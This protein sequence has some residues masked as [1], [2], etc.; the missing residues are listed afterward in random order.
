[1]KKVL[2]IDADSMIWI[3][4][5]NKKNTIPKTLDEC[6]ESIDGLLK[7]IMGATFGT[8]YILCITVGRSFRYEIY[9]EYKGNRKYTDKSE[10]FDR[11]K[12]YLIIKYKAYYQNGLEADDVVNI[13][14][15]RI[16]NSFI[17]SADKDVLLLEG[18]NF[19]YRHFKWIKTTK[20]ESEEAFWS[21]MV[22]GQVGDNIKGIPGKGKAFVEKL[23]E[24]GDGIITNQMR[25]FREYLNHFGE[26]KG[27][28]E[29]YKNY[30]SLKIVDDW[31]LKDLP[32][33][34]EYKYENNEN[35]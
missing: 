11:I 20:E 24:G 15:K 1:M 33:P 22:S 14:H 9:P 5:H 21:D 7:N 18:K 10:H 32:I 30:K 26:N 23:F 27:I 31:E 25:V 3:G 12:E 17:A 19:D 35:V 2:I 8:H 16:E 29:F 4:C 6:K 34:I 13:L 28:E